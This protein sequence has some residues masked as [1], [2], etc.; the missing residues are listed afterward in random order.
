MVYKIAMV[1]SILNSKDKDI[2]CADLYF[3]IS[4]SLVT[5]VFYENS[6][7]LLKKMGGKTVKTSSYKVVYEFLPDS[8]TR[9]QAVQVFKKAGLKERSTDAYLVKMA[10]DGLIAKKAHGA[11]EKL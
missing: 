8:F 10:N 7:Q 1:L 6:Y 11:Y 3:D 9:K 2:I 4:L 5:H